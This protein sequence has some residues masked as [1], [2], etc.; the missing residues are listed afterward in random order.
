[1][2]IMM[3]EIDDI[4][5]KISDVQL[6]D[7]IV[8]NPFAPAITGSLST[9][10]KLKWDGQQSIDGNGTVTLADFTYDGQPVG[11]FVSDLDIATNMDGMIRANGDLLVD[12]KKTMTIAGVLNDSTAVSPFD[13][14]LQMI[15]FPLHIAN[16]FLP[17]DM[18]S[19]S[20][21]LN[22]SMRVS[23][24]MADPRL[25]GHINFEDAAVK[26]DH[27]QYIVQIL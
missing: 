15:Q 5:L 12:G 10:L 27:D 19:L 6:A 23:G 3:L 17:A 16:P 26:F 2:K 22:G 14:D 13:L 25:N 11:T 9:D 24:D 18:A 7:W 20:G 1:M 21:M 4:Y 8:I